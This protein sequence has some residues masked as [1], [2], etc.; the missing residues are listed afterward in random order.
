M[1][2]SLAVDDVLA[3]FDTKISAARWLEANGSLHDQNVATN[4]RQSLESVRRGLL[5][6]VET[7]Q[8]TQHSLNQQRLRLVG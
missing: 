3:L 5:E 7:E 4:V 1:I 6:R 8:R 2:V